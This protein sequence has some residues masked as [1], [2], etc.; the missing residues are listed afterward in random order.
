MALVAVAPETVARLLH[1]HVRRPVPHRVRHARCPGSC[2][3]G[4]VHRRSRVP[5]GLAVHV[6]RRDA[7]P[8]GNRRHRDPLRPRSR[9]VR[10]RSPVRRRRPRARRTAAARHL[11]RQGTDRGI[12]IETALR[13]GR[14]RLRA[15]RR[16]SA[17][18]PD[19]APRHASSSTSTWTAPPTESTAA[20][21]YETVAARTSTPLVMILPI[22]VLVVVGMGLPSP[23]VS[24]RARSTL[25]RASSTPLAMPPRSSMVNGD[26]R[27]PRPPSGRRLRRGD[28]RWRGD[29][30]SGHRPRARAD[31]SVTPAGEDR[32]ERR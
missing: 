9:R 24:S 22:V 2:R 28:H 30:G 27:S 13:L 15:W 11:R 31:R 5:Q 3:N 8:M 20:D 6:R 12:R 1:R 19:F 23:P 10:R 29:H 17:R 16:A 14:D 18:P 21:H 32:D 7:P 25:R 4:V 26:P